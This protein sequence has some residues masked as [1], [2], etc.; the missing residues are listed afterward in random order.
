MNKG[1]LCFLIVIVLALFISCSKHEN[2]TPNKWLSYSWNNR[3]FLVEDF[4]DNYSII[5]MS[6]TEIVGLLGEET[7]EDPAMSGYSIS[8]ASED[9]LVYA[10]GE[11]HGAKGYNISLIIDFDEHDYQLL[12]YQQ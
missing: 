3:Q 10:F 9:N 4:L 6:R 12:T 1:I 8:Y 7:S 2:F 5:G 11:K